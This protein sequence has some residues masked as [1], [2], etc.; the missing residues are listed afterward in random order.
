MKQVQ[1]LILS[2]RLSYGPKQ[3]KARLINA[4]SCYRK[5]NTS[6]RSRF[7]LLKFTL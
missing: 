5:E 3:L 2:S 7:L 6:F 4:I 1:N